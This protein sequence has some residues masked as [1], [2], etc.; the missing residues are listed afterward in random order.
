MNRKTRRRVRRLIDE[1][2]SYDSYD[3]WYA[4]VKKKRCLNELAELFSIPRVNA[5]CEEHGIRPGKNYD[6][7]L[8]DN[9]LDKGTRDRVFRE[10][11]QDD[12]ELVV[13]T[14]PCTLF[15]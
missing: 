9:L 1:L 3:T 2:Q 7:V 13:V 12:P 6:L 15:F 5:I 4:A 10:I 11:V 8:G 14:P